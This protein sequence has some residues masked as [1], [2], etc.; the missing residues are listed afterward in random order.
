MYVCFKCTPVSWQF[1]IQLTWH[2]V[3][4]QDAGSFDLFRITMISTESENWDEEGSLGSLPIYEAF[5]LTLQ[6]LP[7]VSEVK[8]LLSR[9]YFQVI[10]DV[11]R[12]LLW[13]FLFSLPKA[14]Q[15]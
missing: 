9:N 15:V 2:K 14:D 12:L 1:I 10:R 5:E 3:V 7:L 4:F 8:R 11:K 6:D 13:F